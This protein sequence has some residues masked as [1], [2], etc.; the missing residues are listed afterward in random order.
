MALKNIFK[1][2][3][4]E[5]CE[6]IKPIENFHRH[7]S[8][9]DGHMCVCKE[10]RPTRKKTTI[11]LGFKTC[12][13]CKITK[14]LNEFYFRPGRKVYESWCKDC[15]KIKVKERQSRPQQL[16]PIEKLCRECKQIKPLNDFVTDNRNKD[17]HKNICTDCVNTYNRRDGV[18]YIRFSTKNLSEEEIAKHYR[19]KEKEKRKNPIFKLRGLVNRSV[20]HAIERLKIFNPTLN[21]SFRIKHLPFTM[22]EFK[23]YLE[24]LFDSRMTWENHGPY[25]PNRFT[26]QIDHIIPQSLLPFDS[27]DHPN[28]LKCW[29]LENLRPLE[30]RE[31]LR[32]GNKLI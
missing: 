7:R 31:N 4:C 23:I 15:D 26:W 16:F 28:F 12:T 27:F 20:T 30:A 11:N 18:R 25:D 5:K 24:S 8:S 14:P 17:K 3:L 2:K 29:S 21:L 1:E 32:K 22:E 10:C 13:H 9:S 19:E 6:Q